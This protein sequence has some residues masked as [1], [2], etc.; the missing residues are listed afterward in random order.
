MRL[1][2][3]LIAIW[4]AAVSAEQLE[5]VYQWSLVDFDTPYNYPVPKDYRGDQTVVNSVEVGYDR[6]FLTLPRIW[7][8]NPA[9]VAWVP[10]NREG[11][12]ANP[13]PVLQVT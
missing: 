4:A 3:A 6:V 8:G 2:G 13:S 11:Y 10:R 12:P 7:T 9:T 5:V 1:I